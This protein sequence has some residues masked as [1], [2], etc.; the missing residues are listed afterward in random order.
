[1]MPGFMYTYNA[2]K[3]KCDNPITRQL[4]EEATR[5]LKKTSSPFILRR[6]KEEVLSDLPE[7]NEEIQYAIFEKKQRELYEGEVVQIRNL[8]NNMGTSGGEKL[9]VLAELT[10]LPPT[11]SDP[12]LVSDHWDGG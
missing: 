5:Q 2:F 4:D 6:L 3:E 11:C 9:E 1:M 12:S 10:R 7:K 8:V